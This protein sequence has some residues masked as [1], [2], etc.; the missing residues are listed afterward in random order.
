MVF[1]ILE[2]FPESW[3]NWSFRWQRP[4]WKYAILCYFQFFCIFLIQMS[5]YL[6]FGC[7]ELNW[8]WFSSFKK[9]SKKK[10][11]CL[12][13]QRTHKISQIGDSVWL[14]LFITLHMPPSA[15][16]S[17]IGFQKKINKNR[18]GSMIKDFPES[19]KQWSFRWPQP[20]RKYAIFA[21]FNIFAYFSS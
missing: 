14:S 13:K 1:I 7:P 9:K 20:C 21:T 8:W 15:G 18:I 2:D 5:K 12:W 11:D 17:G 16:L 6:N 19:Q 4:F 10:K 3:N